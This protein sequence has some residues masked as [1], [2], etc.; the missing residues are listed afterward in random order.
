MKKKT[1]TSQSAFFNIRTVI[2]LA[3]CLF[4][5]KE[6]LYRDLHDAV[7]PDDER[8]RGRV[9][10]SQQQLGKCRKNINIK[11]TPSRGPLSPV[12]L[13]AARAPIRGR[14]TQLQSSWAG[15]LA[16]RA[17]LFPEDRR[18]VTINSKSEPA[19]PWEGPRGNRRTLTKV[20]GHE[21]VLVILSGRPTVWRNK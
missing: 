15:R 21:F 14:T 2:G 3:L 10:K 17:H 20:I 11:A 8:S 5:H 18:L 1:S 12:G 19:C 4:D 13:A 6:D 16:K 7:L 9:G